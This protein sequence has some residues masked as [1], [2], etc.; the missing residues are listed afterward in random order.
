[1]RSATCL[2]GVTPSSFSRSSSTRSMPAAQQVIGVR[3]ADNM[4]IRDQYWCLQSPQLIS[5]IMYWQYTSRHQSAML[6]WN[7]CNA[8]VANKS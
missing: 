8:N 4:A 1:M 2:S 6:H 3:F 7:G 5:M